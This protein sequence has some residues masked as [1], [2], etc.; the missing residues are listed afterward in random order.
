MNDEVLTM[1]GRILYDT[2]DW[3]QPNISFGKEHVVLSYG[4]LGDVLS[5][6][7]FDLDGLRVLWVSGDGQIGS[8]WPLPDDV[9]KKLDTILTDA[10]SWEYL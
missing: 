5:V 6:E 4:D 3:R 8:R 2:R 9:K 7:I 10:I 1:L